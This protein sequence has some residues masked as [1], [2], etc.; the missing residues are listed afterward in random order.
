[1]RRRDCFIIEHGCKYEGGGVV[2]VSLDLDK[3]I[4]Y[5]DKMIVE[6][7]IKDDE[8]YER[9][10]KRHVEFMLKHAEKYD[11]DPKTYKGEDYEHTREKWAEEDP[12]SY[13]KY[14]SNGMD[15]ISIVKQEM[16]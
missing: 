5:A 16:I 14:W 1:M 15:Y 10:L 4:E 6:Q 9:S 8:Y 3:A 2:A 13:E 7:Q 11:I 12:Y